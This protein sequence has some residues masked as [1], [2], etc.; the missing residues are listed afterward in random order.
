MN[1]YTCIMSMSTLLIISEIR[2]SLTPKTLF[3][4]N[5]TFK[6]DET[7]P[8]VVGSAETGT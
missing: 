8:R 4:Q 2:T 7:T 1:M 5:L 6:I 3:G